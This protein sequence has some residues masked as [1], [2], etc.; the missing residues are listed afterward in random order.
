[1]DEL[2]LSQKL[3]TANEN[4]LKE[5]LRQAEAYLDAQLSS[6]IAADQRAYTF[7]G[8]ASAAAVVLIGGAYS[9][10]TMKPPTASMAL[11][12][13]AVAAVLIGAAWWAVDSAR[14]VDFGFP[15]SQ[16]ENWVEDVSGKKR[17]ETSLAEQCHHY[18]D[19]IV[20][21]RAT[22]ELNSLLFNRATEAALKGLFLGGVAFVGWLLNLIYP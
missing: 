10:A 16:P 8:L 11:V 18:D 21:N 19:L 2:P 5:I 4:N 12:A 7:A 22:M 9:L 20:K 13:S 14:S 1:M 6:A 3:Q 15:G 17:W